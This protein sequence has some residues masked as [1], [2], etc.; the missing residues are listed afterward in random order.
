MNQI[1]V[2]N[3]ENMGTK[4]N[5][6][7]IIRFFA[8]VAIVFALVLVGEGAF[9]LYNNHANKKEYAKPELAY[10][11]NGSSINMKVNGEIGINKIIYSWG[12][13]NE[14]VRKAEGKKNINF[15]IEIPQGDNILKMKVIDVEGNT[16]KFQDISLSFT[17]SDDTIKPVISIEKVDGKISATA[18]DEKELDYFSYQW[19]DSEEI[20]VTPSENDKKVITQ[21]IDVE[22]GTKKLTLVAVD[23]SGNKQVLTRKVIGSNGPTISASIAEDNFVVKV[24]DEI[25]ITKI[26]YTLNGET[27]QVENIPQGAKEFE[28]R[29]PLKEGA[30]YLKINA[31]ENGIMTEYKCKKTK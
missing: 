16:T 24:V 3:D 5:I 2:T 12:N 6:N 27:S 23:K 18:M 20:K 28:F 31:Y 22:K 7:P 25:E 4:N 29:V 13:G 9:N 30:N 8:V 26:E 11:K 10:E 14:T 1:L 19:E 15:D 21:L 17:E